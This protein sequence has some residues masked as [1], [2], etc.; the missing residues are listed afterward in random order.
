M[1]APLLYM[2]ALGGIGAAVMFSGYSQVLRS[3]AE[4]TA[5]NAARQQLNAAGQTLSASSALDAATSTIVQPPA[6]LALSSVADT[7]RLP[8]NYETANTTGAPTSYGV[9]DVGTGVRQLDPWGKYYIYCRWENQVST[10]AAPSIM[11]ISGGPDGQ[12][13]TKCGDTVAQGDDRINKLSVAE[14]INRAN[15][16]QVNTASQVKYGIA[17]NPVQVNA[18]GSIQASSLTLSRKLHLYV[19]ASGAATPAM[20][21]HLI[22]EN[23]GN[24]YL[25]FMTP[26][27]AQAGLTFGNPTANNVGSLNYDL[28]TNYM[29]FVTNS[30][31]RMRINSSGKVGIGTA[32]PSALL[33]VGSGGVSAI[34]DIQVHNATAAYVSTVND[35][36]SVKAFMGSDSSAVGIFGTL[37]NHG[38][39]LRTN[40]TERVRI[41]TSGNVGIG[42]ATPGKNLEVAGMI[43]SV[44]GSGAFGFS[45]LGTGGGTLWANASYDPANAGAN[46]NSVMTLLP[47]GS[48]GIGTT[49]PAGKLTIAGAG[50]TVATAGM[51][52]YTSGNASGY[53]AWAARAYIDTPTGSW[54]T[55]PFVF[56][57]PNTSGSEV[58]TLTLLNGNVGIGTVTPGAPL[59]VVGVNNP[60]AT[61]LI[62]SPTTAGAGNGLRVISGT[63]SSDYSFRVDNATNSANYLTVRGDGNV[64][65]GTT[66]PGAKLVV[67]GDTY[68]NN[69]YHTSDRRLKANIK[70]AAG[71]AIVEKLTGVTFNWKKDGKASAGVIAQDTEAVF[72]AAVVTDNQGMKLVSYDALIAPLIEAVKEL[73]AEN[74]NQ[75]SEIK[76][77]ATQFDTYRSA[78]P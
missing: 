66:T 8:G 44:S 37:S 59:T 54:G 16:W 53:S 62:N 5:I 2:L 41:D 45:P 3:N 68:S 38:M 4:M 6:A 34:G 30:N 72:P 74:D 40:N 24:A 23:N 50:G 73:K 9:I 26:A 21:G 36:N 29:Y 57:V 61:L 7:S 49:S 19:G 43:N 63:N 76:A 39:V 70:T 20:N 56:S 52:W 12:I 1:L 10:P 18:D 31:E 78:H 25:Q 11:V 69:Y 71:L 46:W 47:S 27:A 48:V 64:G 65:I 14:A 33:Q 15:V 55:A 42:T 32:S 51:E 13:Q 77:L 75:V 35:A 67:I 17:S 58:K 60:G 28:N 22:I